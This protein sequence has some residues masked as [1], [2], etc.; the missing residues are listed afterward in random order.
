MKKTL[1]LTAALA[2]AACA[3]VDKPAANGATAQAS[4]AAYYCW[5]DRLSTEGDALMCNWEANASDACRSSGRTPLSKAAIA[6]GPNDVKR[7]DNGQWL[8]KV[9]TR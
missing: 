4:A 7:C 1:A 6:S 9:T 3:A 5:K 8:V 2:L